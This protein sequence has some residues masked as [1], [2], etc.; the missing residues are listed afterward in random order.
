MRLSI[1]DM[2]A[3]RKRKLE[4]GTVGKP[5]LCLP[6]YTC[7]LSTPCSLWHRHTDK[8]R[9]LHKIRSDPRSGQGWGFEEGWV[10]GLNRMCSREKSWLR[11]NRRGRDGCGVEEGRV[12]ELGGVRCCRTR[13]CC[14]RLEYNPRCA[15]PCYFRRLDDM[16][17]TTSLR[18]SSAPRSF[19]VE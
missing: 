3:G 8:V 4:D 6:D 17:R 14:S 1:E 5:L 2:K 12:W 18:I 16:A 19:G 10:W 11:C 15:P 9:A 13:P 7:A